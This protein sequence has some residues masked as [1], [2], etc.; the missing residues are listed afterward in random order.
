M[1]IEGDTELAVLESRWEYSPFRFVEI[2]YIYS[3]E[4]LDSRNTKKKFTTISLSTWSLLL[5]FLFV[6][7]LLILPTLHC[8]KLLI[9]FKKQKNFFLNSR[10][11]GRPNLIYL[12]VINLV[13][14]LSI[15]LC[16][17]IRSSCKPE[18][19]IPSSPF[20]VFFSRESASHWSRREAKISCCCASAVQR[21]KKAFE[22]VWG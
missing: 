7:Y 11:Y 22:K 20:H 3:S 4:A 5:F 21:Y 17:A 19:Q 9:L 1:T 2:Q 6:F 18:N 12:E 8:P 16:F 10:V 14:S 15:F 13:V